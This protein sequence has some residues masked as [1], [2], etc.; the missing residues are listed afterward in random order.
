MGT[1]R[2]LWCFHTLVRNSQLYVQYFSEL[3]YWTIFFP[4]S[5]F[6]TCYIQSFSYVCHLEKGNCVV[7]KYEFIF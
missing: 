6:S 7:V 2:D 5:E 4:S 3:K 1:R